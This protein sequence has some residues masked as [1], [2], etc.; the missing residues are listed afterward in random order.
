LTG[1]RKLR[2]SWIAARGATI[3]R[4]LIDV[5]ARAARHGRGHLT[6]H[7]PAWRHHEAEWLS[8][9]QA[10]CGPPFQCAAWPSSERRHVPGVVWGS[11][12]P[13]VNTSRDG[14][15]VPRW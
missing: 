10:V 3:R 5:A 7:L 2:S 9:F 14:S 12:C 15:L 11:S 4:D 13:L 8:L 6:L 1:P